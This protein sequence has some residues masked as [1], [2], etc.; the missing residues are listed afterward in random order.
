LDESDCKM[1]Q[2]T[3]D[4]LRPAAEDRIAMSHFQQ[5]PFL[6]IPINSELLV[7]IL[8]FVYNFNTCALI[9]SWYASLIHRFPRI[10]QFS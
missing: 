2:V 10:F 8:N 9:L 6:R 4:L 7:P 5:N 1:D 3:N